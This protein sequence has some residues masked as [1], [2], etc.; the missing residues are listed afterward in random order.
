MRNGLR[1]VSHN[2]RGQSDMLHATNIQVCIFNIPG[3]CK[4]ISNDVLTLETIKLHSEV[5]IWFLK[6]IFNTSQTFS[7]LSASV[8]VPP[9]SKI[10]LSPGKWSGIIEIIQQLKKQQ[11]SEKRGEGKGRW[12]G[13]SGG[14]EGRTEI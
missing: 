14:K 2:G 11:Q 1:C 9:T 7:T 3:T 6:L 4:N 13:L 8:S 10:N 12:S 5:M